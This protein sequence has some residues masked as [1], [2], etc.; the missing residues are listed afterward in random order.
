MIDLPRIDDA[1]GL[2]R[3]HSRDRVWLQD[4]PSNLMVINAVLTL[5]R[6]SIED[7][8]RVWQERVLDAEVDGERPYLRF[9][10]MVVARGR[11]LY[12]RPDPDFDLGRHIFTVEDPDLALT[13][14]SWGVD[15]VFSGNPRL[16]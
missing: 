4:S 12:W 5:D 10:W 8:R 15:A 11:K 9:F 14:L 2:E 6:I 1:S 7:L 3:V 16:I 13:L